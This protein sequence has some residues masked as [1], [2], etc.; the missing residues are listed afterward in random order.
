MQEGL[1]EKKNSAGAQVE[2]DSVSF[3]RC[4]REQGKLFEGPVKNTY[5]GLGA[6]SVYQ[7]A[8]CENGI[9][10][11]K[12]LF[13]QSVANA[14][15]LNEVTSEL[16]PLINSGLEQASLGVKVYALRLG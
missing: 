13:R 3:A 16:K 8:L 12:L 11:S 10:K 6:T 2:P 9:P 1:G 14:F 4:A 15:A 7:F 5:F